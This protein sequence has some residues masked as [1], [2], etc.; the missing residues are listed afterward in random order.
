MFGLNSFS[1]SPFSAI[2]VSEIISANIVCSAQVTVNTV[3]DVFNNIAN[4][5]ATAV[6][7]AIAD[8]TLG[9]ISSINCIATVTAKANAIFS[10]SALINE[11]T[12]ITV[13][14][15]K[16]GEEWTTVAQGTDTWLQQG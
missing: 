14:G 11:T 1:K 5:T 7:S 10:S 8:L 4:I 9:G 15:F 13:I 12:T 3:V 16:Q 2:S 6:V